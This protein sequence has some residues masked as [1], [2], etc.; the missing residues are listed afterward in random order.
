[1]NTPDYPL[2]EPSDTYR[3]SRCGHPINEEWIDH[4]AS[5]AGDYVCRDCAAVERGE[6]L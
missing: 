1:M 5:E 6:D 4:G 3:C 2:Q